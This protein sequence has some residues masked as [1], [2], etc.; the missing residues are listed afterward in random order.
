[1]KSIS[2]LL[3]A[4]LFLIFGCAKNNEEKLFPKDNST[5]CDTSSVSFSKDVLPIFQNSCNSCHSG[6]QPLN[7]MDLSSHDGAVKVANTGRLLGAINH[8]SGYSAM[9]KEGKLSNCNIN[10]ITAWINKGKPNN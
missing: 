5:N 3:L 9:P 7:G 8:Q 10:K 4:W 6:N 2:I 1:M